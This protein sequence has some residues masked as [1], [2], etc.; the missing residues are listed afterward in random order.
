M[1]AMILAAGRGE[2]MRPLTDNLPKPLLPYRGKPLIVHVLEQCRAAGIH[3]FVVNLSYLPLKIQ[4][5]LQDGRAWGVNITYALEEQGP[6]GMAGGVINALPYLGNAPFLVL[7]ADV[8]TD[9]PIARL[10]A[11]AP[12]V[13]CAHLVLVDNPPF[14]PNGDFHLTQEGVIQLHGTPKWNY[15]GM[16]VYHPQI[17][18]QYPPGERAMVPALRSFIEAGQI[19]GEHY[20]GVWCNIG[21]PQDYESLQQG[22]Y[23]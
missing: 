23:V 14:H 2:R 13:Q 6:L 5:T 22:A 12:S 20:A 21:T 8:L 17:F 10:V 7:S 9:F 16:G 19:T 4:D 18:A 3:D 15:A 11:R 1:K